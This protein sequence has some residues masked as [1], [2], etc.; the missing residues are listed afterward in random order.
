[1]RAHDRRTGVGRL[2]YRALLRILAAQNYYNAFAGIALP[3]DAS[4]AL[5]RNLGF[6]E[7]AR[8]RNVGYKA[9][10]WR[11][12]IWLQHSLR[13]AELPPKEPHALAALDARELVACLEAERM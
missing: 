12:T 10:A 11:D 2:T 3:N 1:M 7:I 4:V 5:H 13:D 8:Y 6:C 9:G